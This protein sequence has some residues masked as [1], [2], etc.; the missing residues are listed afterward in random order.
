VPTDSPDL[1]ASDADRE[2][3]AERL[4]VAAAEG[5]LDHEEL[6]ERL[7]LTYAAKLCSELAHLTADV[8]PAAPAALPAPAPTF[9]RPRPRANAFAVASI[10]ASLLWVVGSALAI[11]FGHVALKQIAASEGEESGR[12]LAIAG[13]AIG[14][15]G[16]LTFTLFLVAAALS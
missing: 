4:R 3:T 6:E 1:R 5:R 8:T 13:L 7:Q 10:V 9:V 16:L 2:A 14:Y 15:F 11:V 12:G